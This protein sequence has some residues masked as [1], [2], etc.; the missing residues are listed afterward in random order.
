MFCC[1]STKTCVTPVLVSFFLLSYPLFW[2][3]A[4]FRVDPQ[5]IA[6]KLLNFSIWNFILYLLKNKI[7]EN[8]HYPE[9][10]LHPEN[11]WRILAEFEKFEQIWGTVKGRTLKLTKKDLKI[12]CVSHVIYLLTYY[13]M[14]PICKIS[15]KYMPEKLQVL[16]NWGK[17][18][19]LPQPTTGIFFGNFIYTTIICNDTPLS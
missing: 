3:W 8:N 9:S 10:L 15:K 5:P 14:Y 4:I 18:A 2:L 6:K 17:M 12:P 13:Y 16:Q 1:S 7:F 11:W 19:H